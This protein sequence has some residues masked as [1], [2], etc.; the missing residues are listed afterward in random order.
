MHNESMKSV[1]IQNIDLP[2]LSRKLDKHIYKVINFFPKNFLDQ[3]NFSFRNISDFYHKDHESKKNPNIFMANKELF[4]IQLTAKSFQIINRNFFNINV[5]K[6]KKS[7]NVLES[8]DDY[9]ESRYFAQV[10][11]LNFNETIFKVSLEGEC[12]FFLTKTS[13]F[14]FYDGI[15]S[16]LADLK[17]YTISDIEEN[18]T[19]EPIE[20]KDIFVINSK[21]YILLDRE[22]RIYSIQ[23]QIIHKKT[24]KFFYSDLI[25]IY[26]ININLDKIAVHENTMYVLGQN[27]LYIIHEGKLKSHINIYFLP[28]S[29]LHVVGNNLYIYSKNKIARINLENFNDL[30]AFKFFPLSKFLLT[31]SE[32]Y[33][34]LFDRVNKFI[35]INNLFFNNNKEEYFISETVAN[36]VKLMI[37]HRNDIISLY[38]KRIIVNK[39]ALHSEK[40]QSESN[41]II[42]CGK[43]KSIPIRQFYQI[44][45][46]NYYRK[47]NETLD[48]NLKTALSTENHIINN[49]ITEVKSVE[50]EEIDFKEYEELLENPIF[51]NNKAN[52]IIKKYKQIVRTKLENKLKNENK[53]EGFIVEECKLIPVEKKGNQLIYQIE[54]QDVEAYHTKFFTDKFYD[55]FKNYKW[56]I[57]EKY[58]EEEIKYDIFNKI[59]DESTKKINK[60]SL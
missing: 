52:E 5:H 34:C 24:E 59:M 22:I 31:F 41:N 21:I 17:D 19:S 18:K 2:I 45:L 33:V 9:E 36:D 58:E 10:H 8:D 48:N 37:S 30:I 6:C 23:L 4:V 51:V 46:E 3:K 29:D 53:K 13:V 42:S 40:N 26:K 55:Y 47:F 14:G 43:K 11:K 50:K 39:N 7:A 12:A 35:K 44:A 16:K 54:Y 27:H 32:N 1:Q 57:N 25:N 38:S 15:Y 56:N 28:I 49:E 20:F 60:T